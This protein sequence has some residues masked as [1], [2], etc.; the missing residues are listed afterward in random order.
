MKDYISITFT[1]NAKGVLGG[2]IVSEVGGQFINE[3]TADWL[4]KTVKKV[5]KYCQ[6]PETG[7][8]FFEV[9]TQNENGQ[10]FDRR[11]CFGIDYANRENGT[12][13]YYDCDV[14]GHFRYEDVKV[15]S[16]PALYKM[17]KSFCIT[18]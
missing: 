11:F 9:A 8:T 1:H 3:D 10:K 14:F 6:K 18:Y 16:A 17:I 13:N 12:I 15:I 7:N 2:T 4:L 5:V